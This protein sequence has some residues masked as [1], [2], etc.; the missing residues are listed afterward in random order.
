MPQPWVGLAFV[1]EAGCLGV[2]VDVGFASFQKEETCALSPI[3]AW[4]GVGKIVKL[5]I[6]Y[7]PSSEPPRH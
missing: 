6:T 5:K 4:V 7:L 2:A 3:G 1:S